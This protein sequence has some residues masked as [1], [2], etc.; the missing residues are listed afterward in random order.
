M[1]LEDEVNTVLITYPHDATEVVDMLPAFIDL[2]L[3][4]QRILMDSQQLITSGVE[5]MQDAV[6]R[7]CKRTLVIQAAR[8]SPRPCC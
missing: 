2:G 4:G 5:Q 3:M 1:S 8:W 6:R 7:R